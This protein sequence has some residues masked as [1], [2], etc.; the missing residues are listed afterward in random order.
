VKSKVAPRRV[1]KVYRPDDL[2]SLTEAVELL[3]DRDRRK[4]DP[5]RARKQRKRYWIGHAV[6]AGHIAE[7]TR[8]S[9]K[10][11]VYGRLVAWAQRRWP[12]TYDDLL[13]IEPIRGAM[14]A[15]VRRMTLVA[16]GHSPPTT[17][18]ACQT[19]LA[20]AM[21][22]IHELQAHVTA[23]LAELDRVRPDA[24]RWQEYC[25]SQSLKAQR[26]PRSEVK[27]FR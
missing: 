5:D 26:R 21:R 12:R 10:C 20:R 16:S 6:K 24:A 3:A 19:E 4:H 17:L 8:Q 11:Y 27:N 14:S 25:R 22:R 9:K 1:A 23:A 13:P 15:T 2:I 18:P 7:A